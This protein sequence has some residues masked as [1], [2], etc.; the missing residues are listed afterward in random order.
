MSGQKHEILFSR[1]DVNYNAL[2]A[3]FRK[4]SVMVREEVRPLCRASAPVVLSGW[5][6]RSWTRSSWEFLQARCPRQVLSANRRRSRN[7]QAKT[8]SPKDSCLR[9]VRPSQMCSPNDL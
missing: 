4:G 2:P 3:R 6:I 5:F 8:P 1:F 7:L 9:R